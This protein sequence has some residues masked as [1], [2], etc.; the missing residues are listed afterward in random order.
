MVILKTALI[1]LAS[2]AR[3][4]VLPV[5]EE[6]HLLIFLTKWA[7][8]SDGLSAHTIDCIVFRQKLGVFYGIDICLTFAAMLP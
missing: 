5:L 3:P 6:R 4:A 8:P 7:N 1:L 2:W